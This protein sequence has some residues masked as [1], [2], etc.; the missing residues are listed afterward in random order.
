MEMGLFCIVY[1]SVAYIR[2][3]LMSIIAVWN[4]SG[5]FF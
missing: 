3:F 4:E 5:F 1:T 2:H